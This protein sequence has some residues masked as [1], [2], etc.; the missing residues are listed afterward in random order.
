MNIC[1]EFIM[2]LAQHNP[3]CLYKYTEDEDGGKEAFEN[4][5][6]QFIEYRDKEG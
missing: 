4:L 3:D 5:Y 2:W 6:A 1:V